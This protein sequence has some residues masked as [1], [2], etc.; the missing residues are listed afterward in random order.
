MLNTPGTRKEPRHSRNHRLEKKLWHDGRRQTPSLGCGTCPERDICGGLRIE[1]AFF[2][3][4]DNCCHRPDS[5]DS[6]CRR[7]PRDFVQ[8]IREIAGFRLDNVPRAARLAEPAIPPVVPLL[9]HGNRREAPFAPPAV[10]LPLYR[11]IAR[12]G[13]EERYGDSRAVADAFRFRQE[14]PVILTGTDKDAPLERWWSLGPG[15]VD[16]IRRLR[17]LGVE[18]VT[19]PNFSMF[20]DRPRWDDMHSMKRIAITHEEFLREDLPA[21]LH[22][23]ARTEQDWERWTEYIVQRSEVTQVA[24]EFATGAGWADRIGWHADQL[25]RLAVNVG[26]PLHLVVRGANG[27]V[28]PKLAAAFAQSTVLDTNS[29]VKAIKRQRAIETESGRITW[30]TSPTPPNAPV[31]ELLT[32]NWSVVRRSFDPAFGNTAVPHAAE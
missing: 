3:C 8:R 17:D 25:A 20:T 26:R 5:C 12:H 11:V 21:A 10:C 2:N 32:H 30:E 22:V 1:G 14:T 4:L 9:Y 13:G 15:R 27:N 19:T 29:F 16:A 6:M 23:N 28:L 24:F 31:D 18:L 7:K